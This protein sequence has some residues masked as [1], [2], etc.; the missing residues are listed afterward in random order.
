MAM[1][2]PTDGIAQVLRGA[3]N[4]YTLPVFLHINIF[5]LRLRGL[6]PCT[7]RCCGH[8]WPRRAGSRTQGPRFK[9]GAERSGD[10]EKVSDV[11]NAV[12]SALDQRCGQA[13][14]PSVGVKTK[15]STPTF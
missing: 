6:V 5:Y 4:S 11:G 8:I 1:P 3:T 7:S 14:T 13:S 12:R 15:A 9:V 10:V 2:R